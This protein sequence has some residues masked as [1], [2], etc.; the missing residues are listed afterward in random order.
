EHFVFGSFEVNVATGELRR[1]GSRIR[2]SEQPFRIL[3]ALLAHP[4]ELVSREQLRD[5]VWTDSTFVDFDDGLNTAINKL[6][7]ALGDAAE[8]P[9]YIETRPGRGYRFIGALQ[10]RETLSVPSPEGSRID[11]DIRQR[12]GL[13]P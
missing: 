1:G 4:G 12:T 13:N 5:Q 9:R 3:I 2:L 11:Y 10:G 7:R 8:N 6:R